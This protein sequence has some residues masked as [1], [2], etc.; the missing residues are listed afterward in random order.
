MTTS[1][2]EIF[3]S[4]TSSDL[5]TCRQL[6]K[7]ALL[8]LKYA[9]VEQ[10][11]FPPDAGL[12]HEKLRHQI[13]SCHAVIHVAGEVYGAEPL[14]READA[15][16]R[17]FTQMEFD[18]ARELGKPVYVFV[19]GEGFS[20][21]DHEPEDDERR[22]LQ[23]AHR[24]RLLATD[25]E[26]TLVTSREELERRI[27][28]LQ[29]LIEQLKKQLRRF[30]SGLKYGLIA[31]ALL[32]G[33]GI[34]WIGQQG[35]GIDQKTDHVIEQ[36]RQTDEQLRQ[37]ISMMADNNMQL[38]SQQSAQQLTDA[39]IFNRV[40]VKTAEQAGIPVAELESA[41][42]LF[43]AAVRSNPGASFMDRA[44]A[45]F[46]EQNFAAAAVNA[47]HAADKAH[48]RRIAAEELATRA[49]KEAT[50]AKTQ[51]REARSLQGQSLYADKRYAQAVSAFE[52]A[53][54]PDII[55][56]TGQ[57]QAWADLNHKLGMAFYDLAKVSTGDDIARCQQQAIAA[58]RAALQVYTREALP[59]DWAMTQN[60]LAIALRNQ[61]MAVEGAARAR[62]LGEAV[63]A[64]RAALEVYT[65]EALPQDWAMTQNNL[66]IALGYQAMAVEGAERARLL[67]EAVTAYRA[68]LEV[69]TREALPQDW[70]MTQNNLAIALRNQAMAAEGAERARLLGE[71]VTAFRA[72]LEV[73]TREALPQNWATTQNNLA[74]ALGDQAMA[75]EGAERARLLGEAVTTY[76][77]ALE[78]R[79]REALPQGWAAT[80]NNLAIDL[81]NQAK[82]VEG[83]ERARLLD[84]AATAYRAVLEVYTREALPQDWAATQNNLAIALR[85]QA[86]AAEGA[87][88]ARLLGKAVTTYQAALEVYTREAL[89]QD[90]AMTQ[91]NLANA[92]RNQAM[93]V[94]GAERARLLGEA[95][96]TKKAALEVYTAESFPEEYSAGMAWIQAIEDEIAQL[97]APP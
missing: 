77:A 6:I 2:P 38:K 17:S 23:Q 93:A 85:N 51:E 12:V 8:T 24:N 22:A 79:T 67:G 33:G 72:A 60:N 37:L 29:I 26:Y 28:A 1:R 63:T 88:R 32:L 83:A 54:N 35:S 95:A 11:N 78:V 65:R 57:P 76:R 92:L 70:A 19:C 16:R 21:D 87:E 4:A 20:Y 75:V 71:A 44:L 58:Y 3:I 48:E 50:A 53:L 59:Q 15:P 42:R 89:P 9:P 18:I 94:E 80:Q 62:L 49:A 73:Y 34:L 31:A 56:R 46:A 74:T 41:I 82:A 90:W 55:S 36:N 10:T 25:H 30:N 84:E 39:E 86:M 14:Q 66:A 68:A 52:H 64:Y 47:G 13:A 97:N 81:A 40:M 96:A 69:Y 43:V 7:E 5:G 91:N 45:D 27:L 61:A